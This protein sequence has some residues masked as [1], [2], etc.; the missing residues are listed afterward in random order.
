[1]VSPKQVKEFYFS[2]DAR[3]I[4]PSNHMPKLHTLLMLFPPPAVCAYRL[5][6]FAAHLFPFKFAPHF[7]FPH[8]AH[9]QHNSRL[10]QNIRCSL[11]MIR[12]HTR[13]KR[14]VSEASAN[15]T[16]HTLKKKKKKNTSSFVGRS[17]SAPK[18][19]SSLVLRL[20]PIGTVSRARFIQLPV[21]TGNSR[22][23]YLFDSFA[24]WHH[25]FLFVFHFVLHWRGTAPCLNSS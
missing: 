1:M 13:Q 25:S 17:G 6:N 2:K 12:R 20:L 19:F 3:G 9:A 24:R 14:I 21:I 16:A 11:L 4:A 5:F 7:F 22:L 23:L 8:V 18:H 10:E 15:S